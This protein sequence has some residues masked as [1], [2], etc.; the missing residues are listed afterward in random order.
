MIKV[1]KIG[2]NVVNNPD[3]IEKFCKDFSEL[4]GPKILVHGGGKMASKVQKDLGKEAVKI[5]GRRVTDEDTLKVVTMVYAGWC[6]KYIVACLQKYGCNA[7]G[8][9]GCDGSAIRADRRPPKTLSDGQ[10]VVDYGFVG[11]VSS[12]SVNTAFIDMLLDNGCVPVFCAIDHNGRGQLLNTNADTIASAVAVAMNGILVFCFEKNGV[13]YDK[14]D[15]SS[16]IPSI[17][18]ALYS[19]L[20]SEGRV[21]DGMIPKLDN[22]FAALRE[23]AA[24]VVIKHSS[25]LLKDSGT[26]LTL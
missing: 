12:A 17:D 11:D 18:P 3:M 2:G 6:N 14:D 1:V 8:L 5:E 4:P 20:K 25:D 10:T 19:K 21:A 16:I 13:L 24:G 22:S 9:A 15:D 23:G 7:V 26:T